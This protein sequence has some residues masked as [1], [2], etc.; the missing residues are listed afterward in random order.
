MQAWDDDARSLTYTRDRERE[1]YDAATFFLKEGS[2][3]SGA[4]HEVILLEDT[5][6]RA[7]SA[8][9]RAVVEEKKKNSIE[10]SGP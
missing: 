7:P 9:G 1:Q 8:C 4:G 5:I 3:K 2:Q 6:V 10:Q